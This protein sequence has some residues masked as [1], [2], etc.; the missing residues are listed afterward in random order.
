MFRERTCLCVGAH[1]CITWLALIFTYFKQKDHSSPPAFFFQRK[2]S[3]RACLIQSPRKS[4]YSLKLW[5]SVDHT[6]R[7]SSLKGFK[8]QLPLKIWEGL[9]VWILTLK[10]SVLHVWWI[11]SFQRI[12]QKPPP[13]AGLDQS[14]IW[15][16]FTFS[17]LLKIWS[18][19]QVTRSQNS[20]GWEALLEIIYSNPLLKQGQLQEATQ[21]HVHLGFE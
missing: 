2:R 21:G 3:L 6:P 5:W 8:V 19:M 14:C 9:K 18:D 17:V 13:G 20:S 1:I 16:R 10:S 4:M 7:P 12:C 11:F 15:C